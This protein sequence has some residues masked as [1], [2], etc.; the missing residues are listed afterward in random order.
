MTKK[1]IIIGFVLALVFILIGG[2]IFVY[3]SLGDVLGWR[4]YPQGD[5]PVLTEESG[6][7]FA[8]YQ[9]EV[10]FSDLG[11]VWAADFV[12]DTSFMLITNSDGILYLGDLETQTTTEISG[13]PE[14]DTRGQGGL[15]DVTILPETDWVYFT[16][17]ASNGQGAATRLG[18]GR[19]DLETASLQNFEVLFTAEPFQSS[20]SHFGSR[21]I[22]AEDYLYM[23]IGDR[24]DKNF[25]NHISQDTSNTIGTTIRLNLDGSIPED[26][27]FVEDSNFAPEIYAFGQRNIQGMAIRPE[28]GEIWQS[29]HGERDGD[30]I[31]KLL[32]G[33]NYGW[34]LVHEGCTY[35]GG[36]QIGGSAFDSDEFVNPAFYW[37]CG[38][39]GFPPA[40]MAFYQGE[41]FLGWNGDLFVGGLASRYLARFEVNEDGTLT[42]IDSM[43]QEEGWRIRDVAL[44]P[45]DEHLYLVV[46]GGGRESVVRVIED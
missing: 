21:V 33:G 35:A 3:F 16:Y 6:E 7:K 45:V 15:L 36:R 4:E 19:L 30:Q 11:S 39:G 8:G 46:E 31:H 20:G 37:E 1:N 38:S 22:L 5:R 2:L 12:P 34:P 44:N 41:K 27:P 23:T 18:R 13:L 17:S 32:T 40:G 42:Q 24:G 29:M 26:N 28:T 43:F 9:S 14:V 10:V 25:N